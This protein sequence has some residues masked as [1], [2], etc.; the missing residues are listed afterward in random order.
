MSLKNKFYHITELIKDIIKKNGKVGVFPIKE[1]SWYDIG[2]WNIYL[3]QIKK[4]KLH[5][6]NYN[7]TIDLFFDIN[8]NLL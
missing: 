2:D 3:E 5:L 6:K 4:T 7:K 1:S 8:F